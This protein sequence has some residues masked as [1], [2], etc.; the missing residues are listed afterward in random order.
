MSAVP[1]VSSRS[2]VRRLWQSRELQ[3]RTGETRS[4]EKEGEMRMTFEDVIV[5][6]CEWDER[7]GVVA[8]VAM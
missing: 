2:S 4:S 1:F 8:E 7:Q 6:E 5:W 3:Q